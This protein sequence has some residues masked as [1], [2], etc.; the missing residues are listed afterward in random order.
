MRFSLLAFL[1][2]VTLPATADIYTYEDDNGRKFI[3]NHAMSGMKL[4]SVVREPGKS[5]GTASSGSAPR[6]KASSNPTPASF[7]RVDSSTQRQ[8][9]DVRRQLLQD[10][11]KTEEGLL[12]NTRTALAA[13]QGKAGPDTAKLNESVRLHEKNIEMLR[14]EL[15]N[16]K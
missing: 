12:A 4:I 6:A 14:K 15:G 7:P 11:L 16:L 10:E 2:L 5:R 8:R 13:K 1:A 3:T 9:D